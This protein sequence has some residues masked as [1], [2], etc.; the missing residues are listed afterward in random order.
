MGANPSRPAV[1]GA[2]VPDDAA[3][4][5]RQGEADGDGDELVIHRGSLV[6]TR[7]PAGPRPNGN[8]RGARSIYHLRFRNER[9]V[10]LAG[11][12]WAGRRLRIQRPP[13]TYRER[14]SRGNHR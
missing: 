9:Q 5:Q 8:I 3:G 6:R 14:A 12:G 7:W 13:P 10:L 4:E 2:L 1:I 11:P